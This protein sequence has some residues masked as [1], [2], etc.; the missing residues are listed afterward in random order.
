MAYGSDV[1]QTRDH[2]ERMMAEEATYIQVMTTTDQEQEAT[3]LADLLLEARLAA[4]VQIVGPITS[5]YWWQ[6][7]V[8]Q[9][10]EWLCV[11][12]TTRRLL[13]RLVATLQDAHSYDVPEITAT[14]IV[15]GN[16]A[17]LEWIGA[18]TE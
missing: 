8:E 13:D 14:P 17:Y 7:E 11:I 16:P 5:R 6:G 12:K 1:L 10:T 15:G 2:G 3:M 4:C 9:A 18:E